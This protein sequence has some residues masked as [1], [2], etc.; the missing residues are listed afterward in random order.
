ML[1]PITT[2]K[3]IERCLAAASCCVELGNDREA[4]AS[5]KAEFREV[6][7]EVSYWQLSGETKAS[8]FLDRMEHELLYRHG[9]VVGRRLYVDFIDAFWIQTW[10]DV[11]LDL[12]RL[13]RPVG[14]LANWH[15]RIDSERILRRRISTHDYGSTAHQN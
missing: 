9:Q 10:I 5:M 3:V 14:N 12:D 8:L 4:N 7:R 13:E 1:E 6:A 2:S 15:L 11:P